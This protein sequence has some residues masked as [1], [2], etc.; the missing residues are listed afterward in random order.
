[1]D[2]I[3]V[4]NYY[5]N[6]YIVRRKIKVMKKFNSNIVLWSS[7]TF[8]IILIFSMNVEYNSANAV[9]NKV[10]N[11][12][13]LKLPTPSTSPYIT[14]DYPRNREHVRTDVLVAEGTSRNSEVIFT[15]LDLQIKGDDW[16]IGDWEKIEAESKWKS[17]IPLE[18]LNVYKLTVVGCK[19]DICSARRSATF[20]NS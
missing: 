14:L 3:G 6:I 10:S 13:K 15:R 8:I 9:A 1:M 4:L 19:S 12:Y 17:E 2:N 20:I 16:E 18:R 5:Q 7:I 11:V